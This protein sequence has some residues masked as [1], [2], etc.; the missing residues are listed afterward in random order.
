M[1][2]KTLWTMLI[3]LSMIIVTAVCLAKPP[4]FESDLAKAMSLSESTK[5]NL[6]VV[7]GADWC[8]HCREL[9]KDVQ[10][11]ESIVDDYIV[12]FINVDNDKDLAKEYGVRSLP[13]CRIFKNNT[14]VKRKIGYE[15]PLRLRKWLD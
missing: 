2:Y 14:E 13:D 7:F 1:T 15:G 12:C 3:S 6:L 5:T 8:G 9:K 10:R 11:K 4:V